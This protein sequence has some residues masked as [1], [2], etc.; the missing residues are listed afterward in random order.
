VDLRRHGY[1]MNTYDP[2]RRR[3]MSMPNPGGYEKKAL[4]QRAQWLKPAPAESSPWFFEVATGKWNRKRTDSAGPKSG[5]GDTFHYVPSLKKAFFAHN[6]KEVAIYDCTGDKW[7]RP[8]VTGPVPP[9]GIDA[10]SCVDTKRDRIYIG[11]GSYPVAPA[12]TNGFRIYDLRSNTW[13]DPKPKGAPARGSNNYP[14]MNALMVYD[15]G[16]D[17]VLLFVHSSHYNK[18]EWLGLYVYDPE[19]NTWTDEPLPLPEKLAQD[20]RPKNGFYSADHNAVVLHSAGDSRDDGVIWVY[21]H[22]SEKK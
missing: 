8:A 17:V 1:Q 6:S 21:R 2:D 22:K 7:E 16:R 15:A 4:P 5:F 19:A 13:I 3:F 10:T 11:G 12:G 9:F 20:R 18:G 14:T